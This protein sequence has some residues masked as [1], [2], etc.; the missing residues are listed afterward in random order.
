[1]STYGRWRARR[2]AWYIR[3]NHATLEAES[4]AWGDIEDELEA[5]EVFGDDGFHGGPSRVC[6]R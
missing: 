4:R 6:T 1:M 2:A 5:G 3:P